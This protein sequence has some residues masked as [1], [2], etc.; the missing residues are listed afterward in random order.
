MSKVAGLVIGGPG[1][2]AIG[3]T[4]DDWMGN[5]KGMIDQFRLY[6]KALSA[7]EVAS[8]FSSKQ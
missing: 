2:F 3:K 6:D 5:F 7:S 8:L 4:P 1:H